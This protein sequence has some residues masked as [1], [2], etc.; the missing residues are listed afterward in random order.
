MSGVRKDNR[1]HGRWWERGDIRGAVTTETTA[2]DRRLGAGR[3]GVKRSGE[4][5]EPD[6]MEPQRHRD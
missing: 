4:R 5:V 2:A 3:P 6:Q 1:R